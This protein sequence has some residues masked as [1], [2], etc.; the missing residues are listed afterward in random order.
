MQHTQ[1]LYAHAM[2]PDK[3]WTISPIMEELKEKA[4]EAELWNLFLPGLSG[5]TQLEYAPMAEEMGRCPFASEV[6]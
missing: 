1:A 5:L 4:K 6:D 2:N 3:Q